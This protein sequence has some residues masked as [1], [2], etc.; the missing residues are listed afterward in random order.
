MRKYA[1]LGLL[2]AFA[3]V[4]VF[5][6]ENQAGIVEI[7]SNLVKLKEKLKNAG[8]GVPNSQALSYDLY[9]EAMS[10]IDYFHQYLEKNPKDKNAPG[11]FLTCSLLV[12][13]AVLQIEEKAI[14]NRISEGKDERDS[15]LYEL[16]NLHLKITDIERSYGTKLQADLLDE[17]KKRDKMLEEAKKIRKEAESRVDDLK[18]ALIQVKKDARGLIISMSDIL[19]AFDK[20]DLT[21]ELKT[22]LAKIAGILLVYKRSSVI[23][24]GHTDNKGAKVYNQKLSEK[25]AENVMNFLV[26]Q[27]IAAGRQKAVGYGQTKPIAPNTTKEGRQ[28]NRRVDLVI[29]DE[30]AAK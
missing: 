9:L 27:G 6:Q 28:Q 15:I 1:V 21:P 7:S 16:N 18:S 24:E 10:R 14:Q 8:Q 5:A 2:V 11:I 29:K 12:E 4:S 20:A 22:S 13:A 17:Q 25:R 26:E 19:F 23:V 3:T 30:E